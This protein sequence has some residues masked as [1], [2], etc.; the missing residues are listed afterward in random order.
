MSRPTLIF[1]GQTASAA[2]APPGV[3]PGM[4]A[5]SHALSVSPQNLTYLPGGSMIY[6]DTRRMEPRNRGLGV[7]AHLEAPTRM[8]G[9][10]PGI[11]K[12]TAAM[13]G[14]HFLFQTEEEE[15]WPF[16]ERS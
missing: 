10:H 7:P 1:F 4:S 9:G 8:P 11:A 2:P 15:T 14:N 3:P 5:R 6:G 12:R 13:G 16:V